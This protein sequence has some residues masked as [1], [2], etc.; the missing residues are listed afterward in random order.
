MKKK[1]SILVAVLFIAAGSVAF[2]QGFTGNGSAAQAGGFIEDGS[3]KGEVFCKNKGGECID[4][5]HFQYIRRLFVYLGCLLA[6]QYAIPC[7][8]FLWEESR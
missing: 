8:M 7:S 6:L 4:S 1:I 2:A 3:S 5:F